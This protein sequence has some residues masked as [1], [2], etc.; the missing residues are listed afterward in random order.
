VQQELARE[1]QPKLL[2]YRLL[3]YQA[4]VGA[5]SANPASAGPASQLATGLCACFSDEPKLRD[6]QVALVIEAERNGHGTRL[7]DPRVLLIEVLWS[8]CHESGRQKLY[9]AEIG[10]DVCAALSLNGDLELHDRMVGSLLKSLGMRTSKLDGKGR[11]IKLD[12][13]TRNLIHQLAGMH[14]VP[15][16]E[17]PFPGCPQCSLVQPIEI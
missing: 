6:E 12:P 4:A 7:T 10:A 5:G 15:S 17:T 9:V 8:R 2:R 11:G 13:P 14:K 3:H 16:A 1:F